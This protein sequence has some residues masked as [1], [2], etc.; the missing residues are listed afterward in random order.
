MKAP[1]TVVLRG[2][3]AEIAPWQ[4]QLA[5]R[6]APSTVVLALADGI[7]GLPEV[8]DKPVHPGVNA[9][10][11]RGVDCLPPIRDA[12]VLERELQTR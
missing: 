1:T 3:D 10:V 5:R 11:C 8:L 9:W 7:A 6:Y 2:R 4:A 12:A